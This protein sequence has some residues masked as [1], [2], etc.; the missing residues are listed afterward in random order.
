MI[1]FRRSVRNWVNFSS[2]RKRKMRTTTKS[3]LIKVNFKCS[4][5]VE[6]LHTRSYILLNRSYRFTRVN[7]ALFTIPAASSCV[8]FVKNGSATVEETLVGPTSSTTWSGPN[9]R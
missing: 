2:K 6:S 4:N 1:V 5:V 3:V 9:I 8:I 7:I